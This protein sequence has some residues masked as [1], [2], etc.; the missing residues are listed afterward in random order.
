MKLD[1]SRKRQILGVVMAAGFAVA[2]RW[3]LR[4]GWVMGTGEDPPENPADPRVSW[5]T[6][7]AW[8]AVSGA[9][10]GVAR[11]VARRLASGIEEA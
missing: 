4:K 10:A 5:R 7:L 9:S 2:T 6:A 1:D 11:T 8:G 3:V